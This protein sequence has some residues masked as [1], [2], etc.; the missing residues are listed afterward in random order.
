VWKLY[1]WMC[2]DCG[3]V[4]EHMVR[5][6]D[7][8]GAPRLVA[9][10]CDCGGSPGG[11]IHRRLAS[12]PAKYLGDRP[13]AP[14]V[15]GG[16]YDTTGYRSVPEY[17]E[18]RDGVTFEEREGPGGRPQKTKVIK[19][20]ALIEHQNTP[21]WRE[22]HEAREAICDENAMKRARLPALKAGKVDL[23]GSKL[24]GDPRLA[25]RRKATN[26]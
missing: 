4:R 3:N 15:Y 2:T 17:P 25:E 26:G 12:A 10:P 6:D 19:A 23:R 13:M 20:S 8:Q 14:R 16:S 24:P 18:L 9:L 11:S 21:Q 1:D 5:P 7:G 22:V